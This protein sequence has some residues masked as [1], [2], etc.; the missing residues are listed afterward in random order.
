MKYY[1]R[2]KMWEFIIIGV[3]M[4]VGFVLGFYQGERFR[5][6]TKVETPQESPLISLYKDS[7]SDMRKQAKL[8]S[9]VKNL[10]QEVETL[11]IYSKIKQND[12]KNDTTNS[13]VLVRFDKLLSINRANKRG[14]LVPSTE[15]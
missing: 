11:Y 7:I 8:D 15:H 5:K 14:K 4:I 2:Q 13:L 1:D 12:Q 6:Q 9:E 3:A 10:K